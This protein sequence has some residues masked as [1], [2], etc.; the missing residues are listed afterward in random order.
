MS[1][2]RSESDPKDVNEQEV[3]RSEKF[4]DSLDLLCD[5]GLS[6]YAIEYYLWLA[7]ETGGLPHELLREMIEEHVR[8][9]NAILA[10]IVNPGHPA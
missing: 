1:G 2:S 4:N 7:Y 5:L 8:R 10:A 6:P 3:A 9:T